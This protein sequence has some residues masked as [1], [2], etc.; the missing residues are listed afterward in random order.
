MYCDSKGNKISENNTVA[1]AKNRKILKGKVFGFSRVGVII[2][3][4]KGRNITVRGGDILVIKK[5]IK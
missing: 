4:S 5:T 2:T 1:Y 3:D